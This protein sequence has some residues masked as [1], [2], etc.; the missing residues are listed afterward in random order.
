MF[1]GLKGKYALVTGGSHGI[2]RATALALAEEGC[3][4]AIC[5]RN[6][7]RIAGTVSEIKAKGVA[8]FGFSTDVL[9]P[10]EIDQVCSEVIQA[11]STIHILVNNGGGG[12]RW[13]SPVIEETPVQVWQEV[14]DKNAM[15]AVRF[16]LWAIPYMR[17]QKWGR[18]VTI[19]STLGRHGGG[20]PWFNMAK[21]AETVL[22]KNLALNPELVRDGITFNSVAPGCIMIPNTGWSKEKEKDPD[23]FKKM[24]NE[25]F[26]LGRMG[27]PEEVADVV[28]F[29]CSTQASLISGAAIAVDGAE[30]LCF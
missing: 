24:V 28:A 16:T 29:V 9:I 22:M 21:V 27:T 19:T 13:G 20:R 30:S 26:P 18:V 15:A 5:A 2:G 23:A 11:W 7:D 8:S 3:N 1:L 17:Q 4:V 12:G 14:Y 6:E 10:E 25:N